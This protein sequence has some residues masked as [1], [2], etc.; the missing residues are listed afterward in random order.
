MRNMLLSDEEVLAK[1]LVWYTLRGDKRGRGVQPLNWNK[2]KMCLTDRN[3]CFNQNGVW[4]KIPLEA[5]R[6]VSRSI[7]GPGKKSMSGISL[8]FNRRIFDS[9]EMEAL[10]AGPE[11]VLERIRKLL[12]SISK[13]KESGEIT[14]TRELRVMYLL[15]KDIRDVRKIAFLLETEPEVVSM[16]FG[17]LRKRNLVDGKMEPTQRGI[18]MI[19]QLEK[20]RPPL[21]LRRH[22]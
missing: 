9:P 18:R 2:G 13:G 6:D 20:D 3:V 19:L 22:L 5:I 16:L 21:R 12:A 1:A 15:Y 14:S 8:S 7:E 11:S 17:E 10:I 4:I